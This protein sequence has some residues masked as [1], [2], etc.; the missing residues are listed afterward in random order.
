MGSYVNGIQEGEWQINLPCSNVPKS[1]DVSYERLLLNGKIFH[2]SVPRDIY[3][4]MKYKF[5]LE[6]EFGWCNYKLNFVK[7]KIEGDFI[8]KQD[9]DLRSKGSMKNNK[10]IGNWKCNC[11]EELLPNS[12][13]LR[14]VPLELSVKTDSPIGTDHS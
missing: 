6:Y 5:P 7:G 10:P 11:R 1:L 4:R 3:G 14:E 13:T 2:D 12:F 8:F 9:G